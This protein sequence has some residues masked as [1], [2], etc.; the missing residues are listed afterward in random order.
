MVPPSTPA[1]GWVG[2]S[3][4][5]KPVPFVAP[6][7][8]RS[9]SEREP[10]AVDASPLDT[11]QEQSPSLLQ[12]AEQEIQR[13]KD[14]AYAAGYTAGE[15]QGFEAGQ[16]RVHAVVES[17]GQALQEVGRLRAQIFEQSEGEVL[18]LALAI[19]RKVLH[20][21]GSFHRD[22][23][24]ALIRAGIKK[25]TQRQDL[26]IRVH[27]A[28]FLFTMSCKAQLMSYL[29][30]IETILFK[31]D[32]T[33]PPGSCVIETPSEIIDLRWDEQLEEIAASLSETYE[34]A[35]Q[36]DVA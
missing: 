26:H 27:P 14:E 31:E 1:T 17:L 30:G 4:D 19:A 5:H 8:D 21:E 25:A 29:D 35:R 24:L 16:Q 23:I 13:L 6:A 9:A 15:A 11:A 2:F 22:S 28:D 33:V 12:D 7:W 34:L 3:T 36:G 20:D 32:E 10:S 18:E